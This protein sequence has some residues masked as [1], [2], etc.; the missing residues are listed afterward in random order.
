[1]DKSGNVFTGKMFE[2]RLWKSDILS[3]GAGFRVRIPTDLFLLCAH[4]YSTKIYGPLSFVVSFVDN[5]YT[6]N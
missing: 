2:K 1:M 6:K 3:K 5:H 4:D